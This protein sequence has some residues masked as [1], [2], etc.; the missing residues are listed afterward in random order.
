MEASL[1]P[2]PWPKAVRPPSDQKRITMNNTIPEGAIIIRFPVCHL[3][4]REIPEDVFRVVFILYLLITMLC[5]YLN[6]IS[7]YNAKKT[8]SGLVSFFF[9]ADQKYLPVVLSVLSNKNRQLYILISR[10]ANKLH[11]CMHGNLK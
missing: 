5:I 4:I 3:L 10:L 11:G 9:K 1:I 6:I 2:T 8:L 7:S